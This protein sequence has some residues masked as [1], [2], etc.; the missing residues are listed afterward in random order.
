[1]KLYAIVYSDTGELVKTTIAQ[2]E[3]RFAI[4]TWSGF[5]FFST[6]REAEVVRAKMM[7]DGFWHRFTEQRKRQR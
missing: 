7:T 1:M 6:K 4:D 2:V 3:R 5:A